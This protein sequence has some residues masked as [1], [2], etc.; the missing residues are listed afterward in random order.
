MDYKVMYFTNPQDRSGEKND[1]NDDVSAQEN[2][3]D[4]PQAL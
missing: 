4:R 2:Q 3:T 1:D